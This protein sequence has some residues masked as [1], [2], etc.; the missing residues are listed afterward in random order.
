M[1]HNL[2]L[3]TASSELKILDTNSNKPPIL[4]STVAI[5]S[6]TCTFKFEI[7]SVSWKNYKHKDL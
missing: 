6:R 7:P 4:T 1:N 2:L 3:L 5:P